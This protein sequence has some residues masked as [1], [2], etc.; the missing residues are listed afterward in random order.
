MTQTEIE[1][2]FWYYQPGTDFPPKGINSIE[3]YKQTERLNLFLTDKKQVKFWCENL[4]KLDYVNFL[5]VS[6]NVTQELFNSIC[7]MNNLIGLNIERNTVTNIDKINSLQ[8]LKY[9]RLANF[10]KIEN[11]NSLGYLSELEVLSLENF[12]LVSNFKVLGNLKRLKG[13]S[14]DGSM[15]GTQKIDNIEFLSNLTRLKYLMF[16]NTSM[17]NKNFDSILNLKELESF[18]SSLN[19]PNSE[20]EKL[21]VL[22]NLKNSNVPIISKT[23]GNSG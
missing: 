8:K 1:K 19:Y 5:W 22:T 23:A 13:L 18:Y 3:D 12:K 7:Q 4:S 16:I 10:K 21:S 6:S 2:G 20:F 9:L 14:I 17:K 11:I 15:Y